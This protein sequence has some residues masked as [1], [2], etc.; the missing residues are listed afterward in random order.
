MTNSYIK[1]I[2]SLI[3]ILIVLIG[4]SPSSQ[5]PS[6]QGDSDSKTPEVPKVLEEMEIKLLEV[7]Y[8]ID[9]M[10][11]IEKSIE[12]KQKAKQ[13][14][15]EETEV[16]QKK[17]EKEEAA[18]KGIDLEMLVEENAVIIPLLKEVEIES[19][20]IDIMQPPDN[21]DKHWYDINGTV[22]DIHR[23]WNVL[24]P[25]LQEVK[26]SKSLTEEFESHLDDTTDIIATKNIEESLMG[27]NL[28]TSYMADFRS[29]FKAKVPGEV[30]KA[31]YLIRE[32]VLFASVDEFDKAMA[33]TNKAKELGDGLRPRIIE[34]K[35]ED[36]AHKYQLSIEDLQQQLKNSNF[37]LTKVKGAIVVKNTVLMV[38]LFESSMK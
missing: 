29:Y 19:T 34:M 9:S 26:V 6:Q 35:G 21:T 13:E 5:K 8:A 18:S 11:G 12:E 15:E 2:T 17:E 23:S 36:V 22:S 32:T 31:Q 38:D 3:L 30:Y 14:E 4:C 28:L 24:E 7:M 25:Q 20:V 33:S 27:L 10:P 37:P 1:K 16:D